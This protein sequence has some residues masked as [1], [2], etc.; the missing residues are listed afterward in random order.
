MTANARA[1]A[2]N[3][4]FVCQRSLGYLSHWRR[5]RAPQQQTSLL[6]FHSW[7]VW[8]HAVVWPACQG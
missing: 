7:L 3:L 5:A 6:H 2:Q 4:G 8:S 1:G